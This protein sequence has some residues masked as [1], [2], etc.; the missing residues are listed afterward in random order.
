MEH[1]VTVF[2]RSREGRR[3][4]SLPEY[5]VPRVDPGSLIPTCLLR[6]TPPELPEISEPELARHFV[7]LSI[8]NHHVDKDLYPL[9]SCTMKYNPKAC[10]DIA[11]HEGFTDLHPMLP[12]D[13]VQGALGVIH[14]L[15]RSLCEITGMD[16]I[17]M[18]PAAGAHGEF[19][20]MLMV[21]A[22]HEDR[23]NPRRKVLIPDSAHGTNP[24]SVRVAGYESVEI[25]SG[26]DGRIDPRALEPY[27]DENLAAIMV[28]N[29]NTL[30]LFETHMSEIAGMVHE[31]GALVYMDG[32]N[33]NALLGIS[34]PGDFG[35]DLVHLNLHKTFSTPHGGG[36]PG[37]GPVAVKADLRPYLPI[38]VVERRGDT[39]HMVEDR[40]K[41]VGRIHT[42]N[43][44]FGVLVKA[45]CYVLM[46]GASGMR[47]V[48]ENAIINANYLLSKLRGDFGVPYG[49]TCKHEFVLSGKSK[50]ASGVRTN[51]IA[52]RLMDFG[53]HP[54][55]VYFPLIV[56][57]A[58]MIEPTETESRDTLDRFIR[59][60]KAI[61]S[62][63]ESHPDKV[64]G[65]PYCTPVRRVDEG[66]AARNL[67]V[68]E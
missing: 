3:A 49:G 58:L 30:G 28:T 14:G 50:L 59:A 40:P 15:G 8:L 23:G 34:R 39:F 25:K 65:A 26:P 64:K 32:A 43:G 21:R 19:T 17:T 22:Y 46:A 61:A 47:E 56:E 36:G 9:G 2:E 41:S 62:E 20:G 53:F 1:E 13:M 44:N 33:M 63:I 60:M 57:E 29:P 42:F 6:P 68:A 18:V 45:Y 67:D 5:D 12:E 27:L 10:E 16:E 4:Y 35:I 24:A 55:T 52:K 11:A 7:N 31:A 54:P 38:P 51:D 66:L 37:S 48:A